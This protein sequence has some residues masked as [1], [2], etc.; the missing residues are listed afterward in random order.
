MSEVILS[1][2]TLSEGKN[3]R[4]DLQRV[5][6]RHGGFALFIGLNP[7]TADAT[8]NDPTI[9]RMMGFARD[10][11]LGGICVVNLFAY[12]TKNPK[13]L[14]NAFDPIGP[15][16]DYHIKGLFNHVYCVKTIACW[17]A[18]KTHGRDEEVMEILESERPDEK[19]Y[20]LGTT[21]KGCPKHPLYLPSITKLEQFKQEKADA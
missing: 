10:W 11:G 4:Y 21:T 13:D 17:G 19:I 7:S 12:R 6:K 3:Y 20:C 9:R 16:N 1:D 2:A 15:M 18:T 5:W 14:K 8:E